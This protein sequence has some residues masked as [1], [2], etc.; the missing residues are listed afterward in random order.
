[1][2]HDVQLLKYL[3]LLRYG[4][5]SDIDVA[6][7]LL[8][9]SSISRLIRKPLTTVIE[10]VKYAA[11]I[12]KY[13]FPD[14]AP[15]RSKLQP[16]HIGYL[17]SPATSEECAHMSLVERSQLFH[18]R[19]GEEKISPT[20]IRRVYLRHRI[21]F[22]NIKRGKREI[23]F[24]DSHYRALFHRMASILNQMRESKTKVVYLDETVFTFSTFKSR[25]WSNQRDRIKVNDSDLKVQTLALVAAIS[26]ED[27]L[28]DFAIHPRSINTET[29]V[30]FVRQLS[31]KLAG[32]DFALFLDNL[33]VHKSGHAK[34][35]FEELNITEIFNVPYCPQFNG[36]ESYFAQIKSTYKKHLL[37][38]VIKGV[39][40]D[41]IDL[42][43]RSL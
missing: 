4:K 40:I 5:H 42:V 17:V 23:D 28:I 33:S 24:T 37:Q 31:Q 20:T 6:K 43:K 15:R 34:L 36:I 21:K 7:P 19:F 22:K 12:S 16:H 38:H 27:G 32:E 39:S 2:K 29:F 26:E 3:L 30:A 35:L 9:Y 25:G 8:N 18:R 10:L 1:M 41:T 13:D 11:C 14:E